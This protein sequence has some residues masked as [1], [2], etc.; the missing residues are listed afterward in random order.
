MWD[1][2]SNNV[3]GT[4]GV[5]PE[6]VFIQGKP[7]S[8][9]SPSHTEGMDSL[10][11]SWLYWKF[12]PYAFALGGYLMHSHSTSVAPSNECENKRTLQKTQRSI[13][14]KAWESL[15]KIDRCPNSNTTNVMGR[16]VFPP[17]PFHEGFCGAP[18]FLSV[19]L[20]YQLLEQPGL[21]VFTP[22]LAVFFFG[23]QIFL[24]I[25]HYYSECAF[26]I[27]FLA[28]G[29]VSNSWECPTCYSNWKVCRVRPWV[30]FGQPCIPDPYRMWTRFQWKQSFVLI[31]PWSICQ[32]YLSWSFRGWSS[33]VKFI[34][35]CLV[36]CSMPSRWEEESVFLPSLCLLHTRLIQTG[37]CY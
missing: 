2:V 21:Q 22:Y 25:F 8:V 32:N 18:G 12:E 24:A 11:I 15:C 1:S 4:W 31:C 33:P 6:I 16:I 9:C 19:I 17:L 36:L 30:P 37:V 5:T 34:R 28:L 10:N 27:C 29:C 3:A 35:G 26:G 20:S 14:Q 23:K 7:T 13:F